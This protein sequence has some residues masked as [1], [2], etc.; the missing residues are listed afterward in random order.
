MHKTRHSKT[1]QALVEFALAATLIFFLLAAAVDLGLIF[2]SLQGIHNAAQEGAAYG[3]RWLIGSSPR[4]LDLNSIR[5]RVRHESGSRGGIGFVNLLDLNNDGIRDVGPNDDSVVGANGTTYQL[6]P[7][8]TRVIDNF[9]QIQL[10][11]DTDTN[12]DPMNDLVAGQP[13]V[14]V[15]PASS[16]LPCYIRV[17]VQLNY[18]LVFPL[19]P[20]FAETRMLH[21]SY[22]VRL[23]D[24][25]TAAGTAA[26]PG[27]FVTVTVPPTPT[28][29]PTAT[30]TPCAAPGTPTLTGTKSGSNAALSWTSVSGATAYRIYR[31]TTGS[32]SVVATIS[33]PTLSTSIALSGTNNSIDYF[34]VS[35]VNACGTEGAQSSRVGVSN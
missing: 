35:A 17:T 22:I 4:A 9:I 31:A 7:D 16:Q 33:A 29:P 21:S 10:L 24:S 19:A 2:F 28:T 23:R 12:G 11:T 25:F 20:S 15:N 27:V 32:Y 18:K 26:T 3:S 14:C 30:P 34:K 1:G 6:M 5:D 8:G 13:T